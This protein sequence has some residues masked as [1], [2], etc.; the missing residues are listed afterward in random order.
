LKSGSEIRCQAVVLAI[1]TTP[2]TE[3]AKSC[4]LDCKRGVLV[5]EYLRTSDKHIYAIGEIAEF[6]GKLFGITAAAEQQAA[7]LAAYLNGDIAS[8]YEGSLPMNLLKMDGIHLCSIGIPEMPVG[9]ATYEEVIFLDRAKRYYKKCIIHHDRLVG[10]ILIGDKTEFTE[11]RAL[12]E[13]KLE[14]SEK[15]LKLLRSGQPAEPV[16]GRLVCSCG[17]VG[18]GNL[19]AKIQEGHVTLGKLCQAS[20][21]GLGCGSCKP[22]IQVILERAS[23]GAPAPE[24]ENVL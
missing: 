22:E 5:D 21:A 24:K 19:N 12:I 16:L 3:L 8:Y 20:G 10:A 23:A 9:D 2:N 15:R 18:E 1:G 17:N 7:V 11:F 14:L 4:G 13:Q 6:Q